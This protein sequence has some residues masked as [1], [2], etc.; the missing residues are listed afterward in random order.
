MSEIEF[1]KYAVMGAGYH[2]PQNSN[3]PFKMNSFVKA[4]YQKCVML[5]ESAL[6]GLGGKKI[7]DFGC[8][9]GVLTYEIVKKGAK[10]YGVD[11]AENAID[12]ARK[13][14]RSLGYDS[15]FEVDSC[16]HTR[17]EDALFDAL[18]SS[19]VIEH[20]QDTERF[21][22]EI[23]RLL[24]PGG[25]GLISSPVRF[26]E[27]PLDALHVIEWFQSEFQSVI[28]S[29]FPES[30]FEYSHPVF[31][32][33]LMNYNGKLRFLVNMLSYFKNPFLNADKWRCPCM[34]YAIF[35]KS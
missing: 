20:V 22:Q 14:H 19:D 8:G 15:V 16:Y 18:V 9:D 35:K 12:F 24:K 28:Q 33:E 11:L 3:H 21:L 25:I 5:L 10:G 31:W 6:G 27:K 23:A 1:K 7:L 17:F 2:W 34:Q 29:R 30:S 13:K 26:T 32:Y 4:R